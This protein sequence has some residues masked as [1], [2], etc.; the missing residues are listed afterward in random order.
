MR[1]ARYLQ[2]EFIIGKMPAGQLVSIDLGC[3]ARTLPG[4][5]G[6]DRFPLP[7]VHVQADMDRLPFHSPIIVPI[8]SL[9]F[10]RSN[11]FWIYPR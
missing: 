1:P 4:F 9:R 6:V 7:G 8:S 5:I 11:M 10:T 3:G 2:L